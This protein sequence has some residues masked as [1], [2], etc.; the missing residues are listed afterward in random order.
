M[1]RLNNKVDYNITV[2]TI[3]LNCGFKGDIHIVDS[4]HYDYFLKEHVI[5]KDDKPHC[6][7]CEGLLLFKDLYGNLINSYTL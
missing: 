5:F 4:K 1:K 3:C 7:L 2:F 6:K